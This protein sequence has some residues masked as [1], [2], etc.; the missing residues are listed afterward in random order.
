MSIFK[1]NFYFDKV[2]D[3]SPEFLKENQIK[4][5]LLDVDNTLTFHDNPSIHDKAGLW[6]EDVK[7]SGVT[8]LIISNNTPERVAPFC[9]SIGLDFVAH[10]RK[11]LSYGVTSALKKFGFNKKDMLIVGDKIFT[12]ILCGKFSRIK[13]ALVVPVELENMPF[14]KVKRFLERIILRGKRNK[15]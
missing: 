4:C 13:T 1:P 10:A 11:P 3:I 7:K 8:A 15:K 2:W 6:L 5:L 9:K 14:F 12:D